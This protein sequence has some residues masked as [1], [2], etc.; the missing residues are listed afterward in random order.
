MLGFRLTATFAGPERQVCC[1]GVTLTVQG[2]A[3]HHLHSII[4]PLL[5]P[6]LPVFFWL[7]G[8]LPADR[9]LIE[10]M[11]DNADRFVVDSAQFL[12]PA[13]SLLRLAGLCADH[14]ACAVGDFNWARLSPWRSLSAQ[15]FDAPPFASSLK[16]LS[17]VEVEYSLAAPSRANLSQALPLIG[18]LA[19]SLDWRPQGQSSS[20]KLWH[21]Q[22]KQGPVTVRLAGRR[23]P[24]VEAGSLTSVRLSAPDAEFFVRRTDD[25]QLVITGARSSS[26][27]AE[28]ER[29]V[30]TETRLAPQ[31]LS[32]E[33]RLLGQNSAFERALGSCLIHCWT[34]CP[35][36]SRLHS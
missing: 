25:P 7:T 10:E 6:D 24:G 31:L 33:L 28:L 19:A 18:W 11:V 15:L 1:E 29:T 22:A 5:V 8:D 26:S 9:H 4:V 35:W 2:R 20:R 12:T 36:S 34:I 27:G 3:V 17:R 23:F 16:T 32:E 14:P 30:R 13:D 21:L